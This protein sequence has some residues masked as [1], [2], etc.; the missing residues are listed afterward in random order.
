MYTWENML[1]RLAG[2]D[3]PPT[4]RFIRLNWCMFFIALVLHNPAD[5]RSVFPFIDLPRLP[6]AEQSSTEGKRTVEQSETLRTWSF[7][8]VV[9]HS[10]RPKFC[11]QPCA[12]SATPHAP[13]GRAIELA[14][15]VITV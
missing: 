11:R 7:V 9:F 13:L 15:I 10:E 6:V 2:A 8:V 12:F 4:K 1:M 14:H 5:Y 3:T